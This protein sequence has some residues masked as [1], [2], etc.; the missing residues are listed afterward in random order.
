M[1]LNDKKLKIKM[2]ANYDLNFLISQLMQKKPGIFY[3]QRFT[4]SVIQEYKKLLIIYVQIGKMA[5]SQL[6]DHI[7]HAHIQNTRRYRHFCNIVFGYYL[8]HQPS[9]GSVSEKM[10]LKIMANQIYGTYV[11]IFKIKPPSGIWGNSPTEDGTC[12]TSNMTQKSRIHALLIC[13]GG[14]GV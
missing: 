10:K 1:S 8:G 5:P 6:I 3:N 4:S 7:W 14:G 12:R 9:G 2:I 11:N 13:A